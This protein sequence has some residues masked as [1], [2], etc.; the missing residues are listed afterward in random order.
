MVVVS[1]VGVLDS[2]SYLSLRTALVKAAT[3]QPAAVLV[4]VDALS[5]P[6][7]SAW[8]VL[9]SAQWLVDDWP[10]VPICVVSAKPEVRRIMRENGITRYLRVFPSRR[11][12]VKALADDAG[13]RRGR[14]LR[15]SRD[16]PRH[17]A[18][19]ALARDLVR[20]MLT[21]W[22]HTEYIEA[23]EAIASELVRNVLA[24]TSSVPR[25]R[26]ELD[27]D[28][29]TIAV[30]DNSTRPAVRREPVDGTFAFSGLG[31]VS[32]LSYTWGSHATD[33]GKIVWATITPDGRRRRQAT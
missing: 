19:Q 3:D 25:V 31:V 13:L 12:G 4:D 24:H 29:F 16:L 1:P 21:Q 10:G 11:A 17:A 32:E 9:T 33:D 2:T 22:E 15:I 7:A 28:R 5:V 27:G 30:A 6:V 23:A 18:S 14:R 8:S 20:R 26:L